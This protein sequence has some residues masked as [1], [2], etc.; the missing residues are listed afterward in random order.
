MTSQTS[1]KSPLAQEAA[2]RLLKRFDT[3]GK[4]LGIT[5]EPV[6]ASSVNKHSSK[7]VVIK[8][9][10]RAF[11]K[12]VGVSTARVSNQVQRAAAMKVAN[13]YVRPVTAED[14]KK[15]EAAARDPKNGR[16]FPI[17]KTI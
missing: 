11:E 15:I 10:Q 3:D 13:E 4:W 12:G 8:P 6:A 14:R 16:K 9:T 2:Q 5:R 7:Y 1:R 17:I